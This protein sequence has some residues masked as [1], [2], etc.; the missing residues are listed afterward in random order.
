MSGGEASKMSQVLSCNTSVKTCRLIG[1]LTFKDIYSLLI[2][3]LNLVQIKLNLHFFPTRK[4][5]FSIN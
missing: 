5:I 1:R 2:N 3:L 4:I